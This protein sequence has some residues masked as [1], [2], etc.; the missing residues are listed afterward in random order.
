MALPITI[1]IV[2]VLTITL[3]AAFA[4]VGAERAIA[5][6]ADKAVSALTVAQT[7]LQKYLAFRTTRPE[8]GDSVRFNVSGGYADVVARVVRR[9]ADTLVRETFI[10]RSTG[11]VIVPALGATTQGKRTVAQFAMWQVGVIRR[12]AAYVAANRA[13]D[14]NPAGQVKLNGADWCG[15]APGLGAI[16]GA[17][18]AHPPP[19][20]GGP[21]R[22]RGR[23]PGASSL[24]AWR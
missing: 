13:R 20:T 21:R 12:I 16:R 7:G 23:R 6:G 14:Q 1:F 8:D 2:T 15:T 5:V 19:G 10:I 17:A 11:N 4:R 18:G 24:A 9:P 22:V 3:A